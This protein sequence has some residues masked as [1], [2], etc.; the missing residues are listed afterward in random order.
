MSLR[1]QPGLCSETIL[2][3]TKKADCVVEDSFEL[4]DLSKCWN[5][6]RVL[7]CPVF[8]VVLIYISLVTSKVEHFF[9]VF[10]IC[11]SIFMN[12]SFH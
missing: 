8:S 1:G 11:I 4:L 6:K 7:P 9:H 5:Y 3:N 2:A 10:I 12:C